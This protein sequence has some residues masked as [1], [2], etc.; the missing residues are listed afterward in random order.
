MEKHAACMKKSRGVY[1]VLV[2]ESEGRKQLGKPMLRRENNL[3][4]DL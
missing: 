4:M 3:K 2:A 1:R